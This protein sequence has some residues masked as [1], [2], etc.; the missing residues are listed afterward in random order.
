MCSLI[1]RDHLF[2]ETVRNQRIP[3][4]SVSPQTKYTFVFKYWNSLKPQLSVF[5]A[6]MKEVKQKSL[7]FSLLLKW[8]KFYLQFI[9]V[10]LKRVQNKLECLSRVETLLTFLSHMLS[11]ACL[12]ILSRSVTLIKARWLEHQNTSLFLSSKLKNS[13]SDS[14]AVSHWWYNGQTSRRNVLFWQKLGPNLSKIEVRTFVRL[15]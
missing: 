8:N 13:H 1:R 7:F 12:Q 15:V 11:T 5:W 14:R 6:E 2:N 10:N 3:D 4:W 9:P